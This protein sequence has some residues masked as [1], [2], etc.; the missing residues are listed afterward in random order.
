MKTDAVGKTY[1]LLDFHISATVAAADP[2]Q[3]EKKS[4]F[5]LNLD[6]GGAVQYIARIRLF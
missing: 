5:L 3:K 1:S 2:L 4:D 6:R